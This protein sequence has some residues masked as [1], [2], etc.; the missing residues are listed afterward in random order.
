MEENKAD[1]LGTSLLLEVI[2]LELHWPLKKRMRL[3]ANNHGGLTCSTVSVKGGERPSSHTL[4]HA[5]VQLKVS[6]IGV[7]WWHNPTDSG[8]LSGGGSYVQ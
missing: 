8:T 7:A 3:P 4:Y 6:W 5:V 2:Q 1:C